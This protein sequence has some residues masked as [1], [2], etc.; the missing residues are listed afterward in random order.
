MTILARWAVM[1]SVVVGLSAAAQGDDWVDRANRQAGLVPGNKAI[2][3][4]LFPALAAMDEPP[5]S[6]RGLRTLAFKRCSFLS[7]D[8]AEW[9]ALAT[10][11][12]GDA[13][14]KVLEAL[15]QVGDATKRWMFALPF[16]R[17]AVESAWAER[18]LCI[19]LG[20]EGMLA[21]AE[22]TYFNGV[23][24]MHLLVTV[25]A[26]RLL[27]EGKG[28]EGLER[29]ED[30]LWFYRY[31]AD[32]ETIVEKRTA[33]DL[34]IQL[35][36]QMRDLAYRGQR[37]KQMTGKGIAKVVASMEERELYIMRVRPPDLTKLFVEQLIESTLGGP[38]GVDAFAVAMARATTAERPIMLFNESAKWREVASGHA[39]VIE[40][41]KQVD[42]V[43]GDYATR[44][45]FEWWDPLLKLPTDFQKMDHRHYAAIVALAG[46]A[47]ALLPLR[48]KLVVELA[49]TRCAMGGAGYT[50]DFEHPA[51]EIVRL[52]PTYV[53]SLK[54]N[55]DAYKYNDWEK[56]LDELLYF[57]P[58]TGQRVEIAGRPGVWDIALPGEGGDE[59]SD[60]PSA[61]QQ[62]MAAAREALKNM[63]ATEEQLAQ[64]DE[65][66]I[67][68]GQ[69]VDEIATQLDGPNGDLIREMLKGSGVLNA[70]GSL[71]R[72]A[73]L[74]ELT[75]GS[76]SA[77]GAAGPTVE[78]DRNTFVLYSVGPDGVDNG[79][80]SYD[81]DMIFWPPLFSMQRG[82]GAH[83]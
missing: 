45:T 71:N 55:L 44:W 19:T 11:A 21:G 76:G 34:M 39:G 32:R 60:G 15:E 58:G 72:D 37:A 57:V 7:P 28:D 65:Q 27:A 83:E 70:D 4:E 17:D 10:W 67:E 69:V 59:G 48:Q 25:E 46:D 38:D 61:M 22:Y 14:V 81:D 52:Q 56:G 3:A 2:E 42:V 20:A 50:L 8:D 6:E 68:P 29:Y 74:A 41:L 16:G 73:M 62:G 18:G 63:G 53:P 12:Q 77:S 49:G 82:R 23:A 43:L 75:A 33:M 51:R 64:F 24:Q 31:L 79:A 1:A 35:C 30:L 54:Q 80:R 78:V 26:N 66:D 13:Q 40:T 47:G 9:D 5:V 36:G